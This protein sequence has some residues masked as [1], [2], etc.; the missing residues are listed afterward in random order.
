MEQVYEFQPLG[1]PSAQ[2]IKELQVRLNAATVDLFVA[3]NAH[4]DSFLR[5]ICE[6]QALLE[7][8]VQVDFESMENAEQLSFSNALWQCGISFS[9]AKCVVNYIMLR[10]SVSYWPLAFF[11]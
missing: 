3:R 10:S 9:N 4:C 1:H 6:L 11:P 7:N 8:D 5:Y 2:R